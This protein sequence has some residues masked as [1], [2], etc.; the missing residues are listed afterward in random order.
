MTVIIVVL[1]F[2]FVGL[3]LR[4]AA[5]GVG[6]FVGLAFG[7]A[8]FGLGEGIFFCR[9]LKGAFCGKI[10]R[11]VAVFSRDL[12]CIN[13]IGLEVGQQ[14]QCQRGGQGRPCSAAVGRIHYDILRRVVCRFPCQSRSVCG[15]LARKC[16]EL[17]NGGLY[18][19]RDQRLK[20]EI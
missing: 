6:G 5:L 15:R 12:I 8:A 18:H 9:C 10:A 7:F 11:D 16:R 3:A 4:C 14:Y 19:S 1:I 13:S 20:C 17:G 2:I